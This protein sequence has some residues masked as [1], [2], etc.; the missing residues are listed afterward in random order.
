MEVIRILIVVVFSQLDTSA[1]TQVHLN[2][3]FTFI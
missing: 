1:Q 3:L 2:D